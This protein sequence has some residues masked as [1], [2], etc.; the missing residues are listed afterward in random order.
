MQPVTV[1]PLFFAARWFLQDDSSERTSGLLRSL[2]GNGQ[3]DYW[4]Y[5]FGMLRGF[6]F[7]FVTALLL[8]ASLRAQDVAGVESRLIGHPLYLRGMWD[9]NQLEFNGDG[10]LHGKSAVTS[11]TTSGL[12]VDSVTTQGTTKLLIHAHRVYIHWGADGTLVR[13]PL[14]IENRVFN[15]FGHQVDK[16]VNRYE[17]KILLHADASG[18]FD[19]VLHATFA[20]GLADMA[21][22]APKFWACWARGYFVAHPDLEMA[23]QTVDDCIQEKSLARA[24]RHTLDGPDFEPP[25]L[26]GDLRLRSPATGITF[27]GAGSDEIAFTVS[28]HGIAVGF[29]IRRPFGSGI[30]EAV[31]QALAE[32]KFAPA[33][34]RGEPVVADMNYVADIATLAR[35]LNQ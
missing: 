8:T 22:S 27:R 28:T 21:G 33:T 31:M 16:F 2:W 5:H 35:S 17:M 12:D 32:A 11:L 19:Q 26:I 7:T 14:K 13:T 29:Q 30:D 10:T 24:L 3:R 20:D 23:Q 25:R 4:C 1:A 18:S 15:E 6:R 34:I 9:E